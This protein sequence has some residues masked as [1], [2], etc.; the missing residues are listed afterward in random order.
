MIFFQEQRIAI[1]EFYFTTKSHGLV[2]NAFQ[3]N[4][5]G[6]TA[7]NVSTITGLVEWFCDTGS[8]AD[9]KRWCRV[10]IVKTKVTDVE[11]A[12]QRS[13]IKR[14]FVYINIIT[15]FIALLNRDER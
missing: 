7:P 9:R 15:E 2:I 5:L 12:L 1:E 8:V 10:S 14:P 4:Y 11:T 13:P 3:Q 6:E